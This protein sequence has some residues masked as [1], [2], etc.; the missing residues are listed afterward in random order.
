[1]AGA[2]LGTLARA[3]PGGQAPPVRQPQVEGQMH[4]L[5]HP[6]G[7]LPGVKLLLWCFFQY[8]YPKYA[9]IATTTATSAAIIIFF[10]SMA[11]YTAWH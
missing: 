6:Q 9:A 4:S 10:W 11:P 3:Q 2:R 1:L 7:Q 8:L 5:A